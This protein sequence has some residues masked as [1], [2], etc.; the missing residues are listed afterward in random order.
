MEKDTK[1]ILSGETPADWVHPYCP[2]CGHRYF[3]LPKVP[4]AQAPSGLCSWCID[5][6]SKEIVIPQD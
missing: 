1:E 2:G 6:L 4:P 3:S 5:E